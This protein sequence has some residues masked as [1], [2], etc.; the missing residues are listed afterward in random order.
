MNIANFPWVNNTVCPLRSRAMIWWYR[1][2]KKSTDWPIAA[3][4]TRAW[5]ANREVR[6]LP[7]R[8]R[9]L[10]TTINVL[11]SVCTSYY[12]CF[13]VLCLWPLLSLETYSNGIDST[14]GAMSLSVR[15]TWYYSCVKNIEI[16]K[17]KYAFS[18]YDKT[19]E[20]VFIMKY[21]WTLSTVV[22]EMLM[23]IYRDVRE[24]KPSDYIH[25]V[26]AIKCYRKV[27][28]EYYIV[29]Y[30]STDF[31]IFFLFTVVLGN[32]IFVA[33]CFFFFLSIKSLTAAKLIA[34]VLMLRILVEITP[35]YTVV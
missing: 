32:I 31:R 33:L 24:N 27:I 23:C 13:G 5:N 11:C 34:R 26:H 1:S 28:Y 19:I 15:R 2:R 8:R 17:K 18:L 21:Y 10:R 25:S 20:S 12:W 4:R 16:K 3:C 6:L 9:Y 7:V 30:I 22:F 14:D 35:M 29:Y